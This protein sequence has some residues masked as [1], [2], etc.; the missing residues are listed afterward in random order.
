MLKLYYY[1]AF[2]V[3]CIF[4]CP[5]D[6]SNISSFL[7]TT[8]STGTSNW[9]GDYFMDTAGVGMV[10]NQSHLSTADNTT[11][12]GQ[13]AAVFNR[14]WTSQYSRSINESY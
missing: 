6:E 2:I 9:S 12:R 14:D 8:I 13:L 10:Y 7:S 3:R 5:N 1:S 11:I 4:F